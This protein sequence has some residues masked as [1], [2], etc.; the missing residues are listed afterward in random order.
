MQLAGELAD[1]TG[2]R[3]EQGALDTEARMQQRSRRSGRPM[4][5]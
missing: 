1:R 3:L 5:P 4:G 2:L